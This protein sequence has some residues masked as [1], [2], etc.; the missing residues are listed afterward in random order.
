MQG[1]SVIVDVENMRAAI[2]G[3][4]NTP[5]I[6]THTADIAKFMA[7]SLDLP[8]W[9]RR[10]VIVGDRITANRLVS[11]VEK[12]RGKSILPHGRLY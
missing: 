7:A 6:F 11:L 9:P 1:I 12:A 10:C 2:P 4:G 8:K 3:E 5:M